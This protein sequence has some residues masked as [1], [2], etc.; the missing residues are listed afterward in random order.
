MLLKPYDPQ[1]VDWF[2]KIKWELDSCLKGSN[3]QIEHVGSTSVPNLDSKPIIDIDIIYKVESDLEKIKSNLCELG[4]YHN[5]NQGIEQREVFKR[6]GAIYHPYLDTIPHHLYVCLKGS[7][8]LERHLLMRDFLRNN[9]WARMHYQ[10]KKYE[11]AELAKQDRKT[12]QELKERFLNPFI[13][14]VVQKQRDSLKL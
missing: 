11:L 12:Y 2:I 4:Y 10:Q 1:W 5:G 3:Y 6:N 14:V 7:S 9:E 13:D 8:P